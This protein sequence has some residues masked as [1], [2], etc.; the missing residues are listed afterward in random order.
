[1]RS[2]GSSSR[3]DNYVVVLYISVL[4]CQHRKKLAVQRLCLKQ[5][6]HMFQG[7]QAGPITVRS[8]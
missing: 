6:M 3:H 1:M 7:V 4:I 5:Y 2:A 8:G